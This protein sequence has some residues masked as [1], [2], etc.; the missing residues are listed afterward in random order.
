M[1]FIF[2]EDDL[3]DL[4]L[5]EMLII[6][7]WNE[8]YPEV[9]PALSSDFEA[10]VEW[11]DSYADPEFNKHVDEDFVAW[12]SEPPEPPSYAEMNP[13]DEFADSNPWEA[14]PEG[15]LRG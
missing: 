9:I 15:D 13:M 6:N 14:G 1:S 8:E 10:V 4:W 11:Y 7:L 12:Q 5:D 2:D 3:W